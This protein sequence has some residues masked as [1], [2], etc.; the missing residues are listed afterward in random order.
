MYKLQF[1]HLYLLLYCLMLTTLSFYSLE[2][3][4]AGWELGD[5]TTFRWFGRY[6]RCEFTEMDD[7][8][9]IKKHFLVFVTILLSRV[10]RNGGI[11]TSNI[12]GDVACWNL[13]HLATFLAS[14]SLQKETPYLWPGADTSDNNIQLIIWPLFDPIVLNRGTFYWSSHIFLC[15][16]HFF[17]A[18]MQ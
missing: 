18:H 16:D 12:L 3:L 8:L 4:E 15:F 13:G 2:Y 1:L 5:L 10:L 17:V 11:F 6:F 14:F 7:I 9:L